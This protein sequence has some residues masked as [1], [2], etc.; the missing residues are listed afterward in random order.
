LLL[1]FAE[2]IASPAFALRARHPDFPE[3]FSRVRKLP[4]P[5]LVAT[6]L[7]MRSGS[8]QALLD[9]FFTNLRAAAGSSTGFPS[10]THRRRLRPPQ[11]NRVT[12]DQRLASFRG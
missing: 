1:D 12:A 2:L 9:T 3:A 5:A 6:L 4:L 8:Q 10:S 7:V 11:P